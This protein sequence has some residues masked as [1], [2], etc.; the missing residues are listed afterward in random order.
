MYYDQDDFMMIRC[1]CGCGLKIDG[2]LSEKNVEFLPNHEKKHG[3]KIH[4]SCFTCPLDDCHI[5]ET[6]C[7]T[8][9]I[10]AGIKVH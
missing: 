8:A 7:L 2:Y 5:N 1:C 3:C 6:M 10:G 9:Q 4:E